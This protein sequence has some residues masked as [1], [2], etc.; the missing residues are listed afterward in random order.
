M[1]L[2]NMVTQNKDMLCNNVMHVYK[3]QQ[4]NAIILDT[5]TILNCTIQT[6][7]DRRVT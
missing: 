1:N 6:F 3:I 4:G 2:H 7:L 5:F